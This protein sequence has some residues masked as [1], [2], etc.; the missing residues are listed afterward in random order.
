V[1]EAYARFIEYVDDGSNELSYAVQLSFI[2]YLILGQFVAL[3][4]WRMVAGRGK[5]EAGWWGRF[6]FVSYLLFAQVGLFV[7]WICLA[8]WWYSTSETPEGKILL[9][10]IVAAVH[11]GIAVAMLLLLAL[12]PIGAW[13]G[14]GWTRNF[15][16]RLIQLL[17]I[18][19]IAGQALVNLECPLSTLERQLRPYPEDSGSKL[20]NLE[21]AT[22]WGRFCHRGIFLASDAP[23]EYRSIGYV[24]VGV[25]VL[26]AWLLIPAR[27]PWRGAPSGQA[28][29]RDGPADQLP[30]ADYHPAKT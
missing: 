29:S 10:D 4:L 25:A 9:A 24:V 5:G 28:A 26:L 3:L 7:G 23:R 12:L 8:G 19:I 11:F 1:R 15:W 22:E 30:R 18:E 20:H 27:L 2:L 17:V 14:W 6:A 13:R 21:G 16:L